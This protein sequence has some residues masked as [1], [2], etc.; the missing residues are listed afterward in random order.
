ME[1]L[2][3]IETPLETQ[4][5]AS[6]LPPLDPENLIRHDPNAH[7]ILERDSSKLARCSLWW[8]NTPPYSNHKLGLIGHYATFNAAAAHQLLQHACAYLYA[9]GCTLAV[10]PM[11]GNTWHH[12]RLMTK[13]GNEPVF[14]LEPDN[15]DEYVSHFLE[16]GFTPFANYSSALTTNLSQKDLRLERVSTRLS[17]LD[18]RIRQLELQ[19]FDS[20]LQHIYAVSVISFRNNFLYTPIEEAEFRNEYSQIVQYIQPE[21]VFIAEHEGQPV[22]F[23][24]AVPDWLQKKRGEKTNTVI[25]KTVAVLPERIYAGLGNLLVAHCHAIAHE[26]GYTRAI[27]AL[28]HDA[29]NSRNLSSRYAQTI[30][31]YTL[32]AKVLE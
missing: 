3:L 17:K 4:S 2:I 8:N 23:L 26:L 11:D 28:M 10:G 1:Q 18:V 7:L 25:I 27:H 9:Q 31:R 14:F 20:E 12:Y 32:F 19:H 16:Q 21:L 6:L 13:R 29:N 22:G 15:P 30:R 24:F 5:L